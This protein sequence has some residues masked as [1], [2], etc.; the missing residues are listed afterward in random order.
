[1]FQECSK[2]QKN[3]DQQSVPADV[4]NSNEENEE[5][6]HIFTYLNHTNPNAGN[7]CPF[8]LASKICT[9]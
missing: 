1:M 6:I 9:V 2:K 5:V 4:L 7:T 8:S 3:N